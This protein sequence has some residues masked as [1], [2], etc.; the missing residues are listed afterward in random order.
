MAEGDIHKHLKEVALFYLK[1]KCVD[2]IANEVKFWNARSVAD[3]VGINLKRKEIRV[4]EVKASYSDFKRDDKLFKEKS[5]YYN[6]AH[7]AY[8][9]CPTDIIPKEE[10]PKGYGLLYVDEYDNII[11]EKN[12][13]KNKG[14]LKTRFNTTLKR[15]ARSL[16]NTFLYHE[17][18]KFNK[19]QTYG[20]FKYKANILLISV[21]C[22]NCRKHTKELIHKD[23][24]KEIICRNRKCKTTINLK[25]S[26]I[27]E[28]T[29]FNNGFINKINTLN[30]EN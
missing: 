5:S 25:K 15:T 21:A 10:I 14:R 27:K 19:D 8:I 6:H 22:P 26:K 1:D 20:K 12:P 16:T 4:I 23:Y 13:T 7:Y 2:L 24:T 17:Q 18:N 28:I 29:G 30:K 3:A 9:M 11:V